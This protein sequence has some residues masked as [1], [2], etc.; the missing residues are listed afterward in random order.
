MIRRAVSVGADSP[1]AVVF[2]LLAQETARSTPFPAWLTP[3]FV[4]AVALLAD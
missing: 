2:E 4:P 1:Y 3:V